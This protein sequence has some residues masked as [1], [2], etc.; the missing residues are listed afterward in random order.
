MPVP[1]DNS[2]PAPDFPDGFAPG[3][4]ALRASQAREQA[5]RAEA[6]HQRRQL[7]NVLEQSAAMICIF[8]GPQHTFQ[9]V[10]PPF[11]ALVGERL[12]L[13]R[14]VVQ[15]LPELADQS[16]FGLLDRVYQTGEAF[17]ATEMLVQLD[18]GPAGPPG[19]ENRYYNFKAIYQPRSGLAGV[20]DGILLFAHEVTAQMQARQHVQRLN[21]NLATANEELQAANEEIRANNDELFRAQHELHLLNEELEARVGRRTRELQL[22]QAETERQKERLEQFF[23]QAPAAICILSGPSLAFELVNPAYRQLLPGRALLDRPL[24]EALP[25]LTGHLVAHALRLVYRTG[26]T[27]AQAGV[28]TPLAPHGRGP[29]RDFYFDYLF[30]ARYDEQ[31]R[32]DGVLVFAFDVTEQLLARQQADAAQAEVLA[33]AQQMVEQRESLYRIFEQAPVGVA[34]FQGPQYLVEMANPHI[35]RLWG[36]TPEQVVGQPLFDAVPEVRD[37]GFQEVL[38]QVMST[39]EAFVAQGILV[40]LERQD[41]LE[42]VYLNFVYQPLRDA[43]GRI[44]SVAA[45]AIEVSEQVR[46][47]QQV[48]SL[49]KELAATN[50]KLRASNEE[51]GDT[52]YQLLRTNADLDNFI[53]TASHD[54][55]APISNIEG[56]LI[57]LREEL[58]LPPAEADVP[59]L[60]NLMQDSVERFKH[61]IGHLTEVTKLQKSHEQPTANVDVAALVEAVRLDLR[62][63]LDATGGYLAVDVA[64]C[65]TIAFSEKN[66]RS[67]V[68]NLLSNAFKY[69]HPARVPQVR[70]R[71]APAG[72]GPVLEVQDNGLGLDAA[73]Q[74]KLFGMFQRLHDHVEGS[75]IGLYMV[76][77]ILDNAGGRIEV[78]SQ[79]NVGSTFRVYFPR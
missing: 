62:P 32:I 12:L 21:E 71:C 48:Q 74:G 13:G 55:K 29:L 46:V 76:K 35:A 78:E 3:D 7:Q 27:Y 25:E 47:R 43:Q 53:Y 41:G 37:Q 69:R 18:R 59:L 73:Q 5:A 20:S 57:A 34:I 61:T 68:F 11:Q 75:G 19:L 50:E 77:K 15:A 38:D 4:L 30:Q 51:L 31:G 14:P 24:L 10:N 22:A 36:R 17:Y 52:N 49:N 2:P 39:G 28:L 33:A 42:R 60:L 67:V 9:F 79:P 6:D 45:V 8:E 23:M 70:L 56:L 44:T 16:L 54:L 66:L 26:K 63:L 40:L 65:P 64:A 58:A 1:A 72:A